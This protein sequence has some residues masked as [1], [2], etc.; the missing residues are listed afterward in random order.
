MSVTL[1]SSGVSITF[2][3]GAV[4]A[5]IDDPDGP[6]IR[7]LDRRMQRAQRGSKRLVRVRTGR[8]LR[9]IRKNRGVNGRGPYVDVVAGWIGGG[10]KGKPRSY[11]MYE[12]DGT[13]PHVIRPRKP[14]GALRFESRGK[15]VFAR[16]V[17]HPG[18]TGTRFLTRALPLAGG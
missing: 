13:P 12:H 1:R 9:S 3:P 18:T 14:N 7:D 10:R 5:F 17:N 8:L 6:V 4:K 16:K 2:Y 15:I 11:V